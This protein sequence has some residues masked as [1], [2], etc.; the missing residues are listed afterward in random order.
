MKE[1]EEY[2]TRYSKLSIQFNLT[3]PKIMFEDLKLK[4]QQ[5]K[6]LI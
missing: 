3:L 2:F 5:T 1:T 4:Q 6:L